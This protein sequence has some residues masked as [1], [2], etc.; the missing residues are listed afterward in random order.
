MFKM[1][2]ET[3]NAAFRYGDEDMGYPEGHL[4]TEEV[5]RILFEVSERVRS[6]LLEGNLYDINGNRVGSYTVE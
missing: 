3:G 5:S 4:C 6:G 2:F 1:E